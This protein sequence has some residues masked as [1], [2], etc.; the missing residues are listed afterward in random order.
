MKFDQKSF[1]EAMDSV[2]KTWDISGSFVVLKDG[3]CLHQNIY[4]Y[5]DRENGVMT[6]K[7]SQY[8]LHAESDFIL[9]L[10]V[11]LLID[12]GKIKLKDTLD[13]F[14]PEYKQAHQITIEHLLRHNSGIPDFYYGGVMVELNQDETHQ[15]LSEIERL[16]VEKQRHYEAA[17]FETVMKLIGEKAL[18][19]V[20]GTAGLN[21][22]ESN[23]IFLT[24]I[25]RRVTGMSVFEFQKQFIY[26]P[27]GMDKVALTTAV[28][29]VS[30][31]VQKETQLV[32]IPLNFA[33]TSVFAV[34]A[35]D[36]TKF[37]MAISNG[38][39]LSKRMW[40]TMMKYDEERTGLALENANGFDCGRIQFLGYGFY[41]YFSHKTGIAFASLVNE[42]QTFKW[43]DNQWH[44]FRRASREVVEAAFTYPVA[45]KMVNLTQ[46]NLWAALNIKVLDD[47]LGYVLEAKASIAMGLVYK[48][49]KPFVLTEGT[50]VI[51]LLVLDIDKKKN[52]YNIDII[53][54]D[55]RYQNRGYGKIML[56]WAIDYL[57]AAGA[58]KLEIGV[59]RFNKAAQKIY[60]SAG[61]VEKSVY[62]EGMQLQMQIES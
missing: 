22:S 49:K 51:G 20:P 5:A 45:P 3:E 25:V 43:V 39:L 13:R 36:M 38:E 4:G 52:H 48:T 15:Q 30:Y 29:T 24:E 59:N 16:R 11:C 17:R 7:S 9:G 46:E 55:H 62:E 31:G 26:E 60:F 28:D 53:Q 57:K 50:R 6:Q 8:L 61:F 34:T 27:L 10:S 21:G 54:I 32:R 2:C 14:I 40:Q 23:G 18:D 12:Q 47:Q 1:S 19:Y 35:E 58:K 42:E 41:F 44:Y 56:N 37:L 33:T